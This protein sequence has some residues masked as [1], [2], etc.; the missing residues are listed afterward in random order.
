MTAVWDGFFR[1]LS[2]LGLG[3]G[4]QAGDFAGVAARHRLIAQPQRQ[5]LAFLKRGVRARYVALGEKRAGLAKDPRV[6]LA[7]FGRRHESCLR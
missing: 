7:F 2:A 6:A 1:A 3:V 4:L 5:L